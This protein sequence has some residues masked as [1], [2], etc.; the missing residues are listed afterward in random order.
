MFIA[1]IILSFLAG[2]SIFLI[3]KNLYT[4]VASLVFL[5]A[6][7][8]LGI[9]SWVHLDEFSSRFFKFDSA[10]VLL[11]FVLALLSIATFYHSRLYLLRHFFTPRQEATY[12][13]SLIMLIMAMCVAYFAENIALL[14]VSIEATTLFV[15]MLIYHERSKVAL[16]A[17]WKYLFVSSTGVAIAF[18]GHSISKHYSQ[19]EQYPRSEHGIHA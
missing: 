11:T 13:A 10:G 9:Y 17:S 14:W 2:L 6:L 16:E 4:K 18:I 12:Y 8:A 15:S 5:A 7:L 3:R 19:R 1:F